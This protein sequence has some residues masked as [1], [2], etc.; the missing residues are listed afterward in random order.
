MHPLVCLVLHPCCHY[1]ESSQSWV[2]FL[3]HPH[4]MP[5]C[6]LV[7][8]P[9]VC[10]KVACQLIGFLLIS[11]IFLFLAALSSSNPHL[12]IELCILQSA[13]CNHLILLSPSSVSAQSFSLINWAMP[14]VH[15]LP[16]VLPSGANIGPLLEIT[17]PSVGSWSEGLSEDGMFGCCICWRGGSIRRPVPV[18]WHDGMC[19]LGVNCKV[20]CDIIPFHNKLYSECCLNQLSI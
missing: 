18:C 2:I 13:S 16:L 6:H 14:V 15:S 10:L 3:I 8:H 1:I 5:T 4:P 20:T 19:V 12:F 9:L 11:S 7:V 17:S